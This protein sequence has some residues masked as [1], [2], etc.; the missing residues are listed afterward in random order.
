[1][2]KAVGYYVEIRRIEDGWCAYLI[3]EE[4]GDEGD[5]EVRVQPMDTWS[6]LMAWLL[7]ST[8]ADVLDD[9]AGA[10]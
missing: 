1:M 4:E 2:E 7:S 9:A 6:D 5:V 10:S 8:W 3:R